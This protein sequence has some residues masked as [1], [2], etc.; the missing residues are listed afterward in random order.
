MEEQEKRLLLRWKFIGISD[1][2]AVKIDIYQVFRHL[3]VKIDKKTRM[4]VC[5][6]Y[7]MTI[8][9]DTIE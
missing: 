4:I 7:E 3:T 8:N 1:S 6:I 5:I 2:D 9:G